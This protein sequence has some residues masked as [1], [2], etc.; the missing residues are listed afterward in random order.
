MKVRRP[1]EDLVQPAQ[2]LLDF[3]YKAG[4]VC[5]LGGSM[6]RHAASVGD[7]DIVVQA[8]SLDSVELPE[9]LDY[10]RSGEKAA[11]GEMDLDGQTLGVDI[12]CATPNQWGTF[13][14]YIT[15][16]KELNVIM[17]QKAKAQGMKLSQFGLFVDGVQIDNGTERGVSEALGMDWIEPIDRQKFV[18]PVGNVY[19]VRS[20]SGDT[21]YAVVQNGFEWSCSCPHHTYR[22]V[23]CKHILQ[24]SDQTILAA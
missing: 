17:R 15:G 13:L 20:S 7:I 22:K 14:W 3:F 23:T 5:E 16:S 24:I 8:D 2:E 6:R 9:W 10:V 1:F 12:W 4:V 21:T 19:E 11:H 18:A